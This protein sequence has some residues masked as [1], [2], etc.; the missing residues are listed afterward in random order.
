MHIGFSR[1]KGGRSGDQASSGLSEQLEE[2]GFT[3]ER[4]KTGTSARVDG[5]SIDFSKM[6]EQKGDEEEQKIFIMVRKPY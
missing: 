3:V 2:L 6:K 5:R 1:V 4:M